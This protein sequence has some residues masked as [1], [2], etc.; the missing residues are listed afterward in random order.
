MAGGANVAMSG[1]EGKAGRR[2]AGESTLDLT[3]AADGM[4]TSAM[5][6]ENVRLELPAGAET[7]QRIITSQTLDGTGEP[8]K[9]LTNTT[10]GGGVTFT[11]V[12][13]PAK[14][15]PA[16]NKAG[17]TARSQKLEASMANDAVE[18]AIFSGGDVTFEEAGLKGCAARVE[19]QPGKNSL[20]LSGATKAGSPMVAEEQ[21]TI[22][23]RTIDV[24]LDTR[25][26]TARGDIEALMHA[27]AKQRCRPAT[28][29]PVG[30]Q[31]A[32][33]V[34]KLLKSDAP[35][36]ITAPSL[37]YDSRTGLASFFDGRVVL[38]QQDTS[39]SARDSLVIDQTKGNLSATG[40]VRST[41]MLDNKRT[42]GNGHE[43]RYFDDK[44]L[45]TFASAPKAASGEVSLISGPDSTI[46]A[47][48]IDL[49]LSPKENTLE[50]MSA[51]KNV[52]L[53][54]GQ[55]KVEG[56]ATLDYKAEDE[57]YVVKGDGVTSVVVITLGA[58]CRQEKGDYVV[59]SKKTD[60]VSVKSNTQSGSSKPTP[61]ACA[62]PTRK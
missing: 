60:S 4:L 31:G 12:P 36:T 28:G 41:L 10:F 21:A 13:L 52:R 54:E 22:E 50:R 59:F 55:H 33:R 25:K 38:R 47:G 6:R 23:G 56:G 58:T 24:A 48:N 51:G 1:T 29:R 34:P 49:T 30:E 39:I 27:P 45:I 43:L 17:R 8:G 2:I 53:T 62:S 20:A 26:M 57:T 44:R 40:D 61:S 11:E 32:N 35:M 14:T 16:D 5:A 18:S 46:R 19:Y 15:T 3:L 9:G 42:Q 37:D 7:P